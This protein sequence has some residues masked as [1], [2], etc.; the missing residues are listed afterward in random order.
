MAQSLTQWKA[1]AER[2]AN[3][4]KR[5]REASKEVGER[6]LGAV[7]AV[8]AGYGVGKFIKNY[9]DK[10]IPSTEIPAVPAVAAAVALAGVAGMA[11]NMSSFAAALGSGGLAGYAAI[12]GMQ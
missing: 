4:A 6:G 3:S 12:K 1:K 11:G 5:A 10:P 7:A 8:G 2:L 9:G